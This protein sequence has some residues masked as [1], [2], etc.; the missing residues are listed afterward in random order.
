MILAGAAVIAVGVLVWLLLV[1]V[2]GVGVG[3]DDAGPWLPR[4]KRGLSDILAADCNSD[5]FLDEVFFVAVVGVV[6]A[7]QRGLSGL[8]HPAVMVGVERRGSR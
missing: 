4:G 1:V 5:D 2:V 8:T 7:G 6:V 3:C